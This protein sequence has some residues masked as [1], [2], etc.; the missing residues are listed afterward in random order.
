MLWSLGD[1]LRLC[2][3]LQHYSMNFISCYLI[4]YYVYIYVY[5][6]LY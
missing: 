3:V 2:L 1:L 6:I 4:L 5:V